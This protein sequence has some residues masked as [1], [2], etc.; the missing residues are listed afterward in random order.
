LSARAAAA[1]FGV[2]ASADADGNLVLTAD[3]AGS[4]PAF[5]AD[6][7]DLGFGSPDVAG[8]D[9]EGTIDGQQATG[10]GNVLTL[11]TGTGGAVG[12]ALDT[13]G[14]TDADIGGLVGSVTY[15]PGLASALSTLVDQFTA[16]N[17][18][19]LTTA[20]KG[21]QS[22][23]TTLQAQIDDWDRRLAAYRALLSQQFTAM[24]TA[25]ATLKSQTSSI[26]ALVNASTSS[27]S[28][29]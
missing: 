8:V 11:P 18:G 9:A 27:S 25:I 22:S 23:V 10:V 16:T 15:A 7:D 17:T 12:L 14:L 6:V 26:A 4:A 2:S 24:E 1:G 28:S 5:V 13:S 21:R 19:T 3:E 20:A 29:N